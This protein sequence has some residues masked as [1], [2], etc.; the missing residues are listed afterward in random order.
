MK[1]LS[2]EAFNRAKQYIMTR[3]R[4]LDRNLFAYTF[5][6][7]GLKG[8]LSALRAYQNPD[9]G[10]G[11]ALEP[12]LRTQASSAIATQQAFNY[13]R[14]IKA[15]ASEAV[16][17]SGIKYLLKTFD[18]QLGVWPIIPPEVEEAPH[19]PWWSFADSAANFD[20]FRAN[21]T[22]ALAG[23]MHYYGSLVPVE[24]LNTV[25]EQLLDHLSTMPD[26]KMNQHDLFCYLALAESLK[27][28]RQ[29]TVLEKLALVVPGS[30]ENDPSKWVEY[31]L[32]P[33]AV[34]PRPESPLAPVLDKTALEANLDYEIEEQLED[35][36]WPLAWSWDF[37]DEAAW[38]Q[39]EQDWKGYHALRKLMVF[40]AYGRLEWQ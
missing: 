20:G 36:S 22:A 10:F 7:G 37:I 17:I 28:A 29:K 1:E 13:L 31:T 26:D 14:E 32:W 33:L 23:H 24:F 15:S 19:A 9:G 5:E 27:G 8:V 34:A 4:D 6:G 21:P 38:A 11:H 2:R 18:T 40:R 12:D 16:V 30:V 35:G 39:A 3:G 25:T